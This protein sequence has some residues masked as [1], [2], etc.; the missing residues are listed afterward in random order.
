MKIK[1][2]ELRKL[3]KEQLLL[4]KNPEWE[5]NDNVPPTFDVDIVLKL[6]RKYPEIEQHF[7]GYKKLFGRRYSNIRAAEIIFKNYILN[8]QFFT[9][10]YQK[11]YDK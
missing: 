8:D 6:A 2:S 1:L 9:D 4:I 11:I 3:I 5:K 10:E 7:Q